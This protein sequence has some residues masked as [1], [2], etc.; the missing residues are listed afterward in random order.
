LKIAL[1]GLGAIG[2]AVARRVLNEGIP[3][4]Q[5]VAVAARDQQKARDTLA[6]MNGAAIPVVEIGDLAGMADLVIECA[7][8][9]L[10]DRIAQPVLRSGKKLLVLSAGALL[11]RPELLELA[12]KHGGQVIIPTGAL[13]GLDAV[14]AAAEGQIHSVQ[15]TTRKPPKGLAGAPYL[16]ENR[17]QIDDVREP[18]RIFSGTARDAA[19]GFPANLNVAVALSLAGIGPDRT[20]LDIW[21][22]PTV[23]RNTHRIQVESDSARMDMTI[24]NIPSENPKTGRITALS[25]IAALRKIY[26]PLRV[27]T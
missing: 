26:S 19:K 5:L 6:G 12:K 3:G 22:D 10:M 4:I 21:A 25:V 9:A 11:P 18:L 2:A 20:R 8:A 23:T 1:A 17:I 7:P 14:C 16:L 15:M 13:L 27:G 24:E